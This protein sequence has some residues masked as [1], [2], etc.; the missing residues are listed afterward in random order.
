ML[1]FVISGLLASLASLRAVISITE[2]FI[3]QLSRH[4]RT[5]ASSSPGHYSLLGRSSQTLISDQ[6][7]INSQMR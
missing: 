2:A 1:F 6:E 3:H 5:F 7:L 4:V